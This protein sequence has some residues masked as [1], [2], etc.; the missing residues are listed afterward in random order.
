MNFG[1]NYASNRKPPQIILYSLPTSSDCIRT[2]KEP[3][4][5]GNDVTFHDTRTLNRSGEA[6][7][8]GEGRSDS[9]LII[10]GRSV[11]LSV[12]ENTLH[13]QQS[14]PLYPLTPQQVRALLAKLMDQ[15]PAVR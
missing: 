13:T 7:A 4:E 12:M 3:T 14:N 9:P 1:H 5:A 8:N 11:H 6:L 10:A 2:R 15:A